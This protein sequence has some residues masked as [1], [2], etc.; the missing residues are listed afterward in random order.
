M[1]RVVRETILIVGNGYAEEAFLKH[2]KCLYASKAAGSV[3]KTSQL[4]KSSSGG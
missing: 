2:L 4:S 3:A 1:A